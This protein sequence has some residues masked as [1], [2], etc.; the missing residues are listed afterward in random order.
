MKNKKQI[1]I[2]DETRSPIM[3]ILLL[4]WP[5]FV[6]QIFTTLVSFADTA[7]VG[8]L[9]AEATAAISIS[10]SPV[11]LLNGLIMSLGVGITALVA[12]ATG[13][14]DEEAV[15]KLMRHALLAIVYVGIPITLVVIALYRQIP[16]WMGADAS[17]LDTAARYNLI[18]SCGRIFSL[19]AMILNSAFRGY[20]DT[21]TPMKA[22]LILNIVNVIG[23]FLLIYPTRTVTVLGIDLTMPGAGLG[24]E[25][26]AI[27]TAVGM[28]VS[29][30]IALRNAFK[31]SNPYRIS[32]R[33]KGSL[34]PD[35]GLSHNIYK[36]SLPAM[37]ER[38]CLSSAGVLVAS[39][40]A[41]LGTVSVAAS[42]LCGTAESLS[43]MPAFA[44]QMAITTLVGQ[45][46][47]ADRPQLAEKF[48]KISNWLGGTIMFF[49]GAALFIFAEPIIGVFTPDQEVIVMAAACLRVEAAI[50][51]PQVIG[52]IYSG[53]L[54]GAGDTGVIFYINAA[55]NWG[56]RTLGMLLGIRVFGLQLEQAYIVVAV[57]ITVRMV[58]FYFRYRGGKWKTVMQRM[59]KKSVV[60]S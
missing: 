47:G 41:S 48:V 35:L 46:L 12:R 1:N 59:E 22:N 21:K 50:Q 27:A 9:G 20:G 16:L 36:I 28:A 58:L 54:R 5:V 30:G 53:A 18:V 38:L 17:F 3:T 49:T 7:M 57:E 13:R 56:I 24:V 19:T 60:K 10:N 4:A 45:A 43:Y 32:L 6:E 33:E 44:F 26:A 8:S 37:L 2:L 14:G 52:W 55:T 23:N 31:K 51:V 25:G 29:G 15:R 42:S 40:I 11:F 34:K 39:S